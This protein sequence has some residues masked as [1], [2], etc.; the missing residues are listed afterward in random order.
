MYKELNV[1]TDYFLQSGTE[2]IP[3]QFGSQ[4]N[5]PFTCGQKIGQTQALN[6]LS[7]PT[8]HRN[9]LPVTFVESP[10]VILRLTD[11][12]M[13][14]KILSRSHCSYRSIN[15]NIDVWHSDDSVNSSASIT[16]MYGCVGYEDWT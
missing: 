14:F 1:S 12:M 16:S 2:V 7:H 5:M 9:K 6:S 11:L 13:F 10:R 8:K 15:N 3:E 4:G